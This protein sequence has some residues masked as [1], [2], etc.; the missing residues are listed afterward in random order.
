MAY[1]DLLGLDNCSLSDVEIM[2][3]IKAARR[4]RNYSPELGP[5]KG[6]IHLQKLEKA[7]IMKGYSDYY[8]K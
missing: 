7:G 3:R 2:R 6:K 5:A 8:A 1:K 4:E